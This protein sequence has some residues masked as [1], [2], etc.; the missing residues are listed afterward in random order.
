MTIDL[1]IKTDALLLN[2]MLLFV[3]DTTHLLTIIT[4]T[5]EKEVR[6]STKK[7]PKSNTSKK[8]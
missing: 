2:P 6:H 7:V 4:Y 3:I 8:N 5:K 1:E